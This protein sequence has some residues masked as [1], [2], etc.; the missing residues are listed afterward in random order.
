[1]SDIAKVR[2]RTRPRPVLLDEGD[3]IEIGITVE[4]KHPRKGSIWVKS[5]ASGTIRPGETPDDARDRIKDFVT[6]TADET[7][8]EYLDA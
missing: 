8:R 3:T 1:M 7:V 4:V 5:G 6:Q 2:R